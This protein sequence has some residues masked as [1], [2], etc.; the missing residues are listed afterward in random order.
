MWWRGL[1]GEKGRRIVYNSSLILIFIPVL[2]C[3]TQELSSSPCF[4][5]PGAPSCL[6]LLDWIEFSD[7]NPIFSGCTVCCSCTDTLYCLFCRHHCEVMQSNI[8]TWSSI[9]Q[10]EK[11]QPNKKSP[12]A[13]TKKHYY[14]NP[15]MSQ[16]LIW[17]LESLIDSRADKHKKNPLGPN[18]S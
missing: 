5:H 2:C 1:G 8:N 6:S 4:S 18:S 3:C 11:K 14:L 15:L 16:K 13:T 12:T 10:K 7:T 17:I 9:T